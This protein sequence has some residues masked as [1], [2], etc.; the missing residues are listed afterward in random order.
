MTPPTILSWD[1]ADR[2]GPLGFEARPRGAHLTSPR[3]AA[4]SD[5]PSHTKDVT[6]VPDVEDG[7]DRFLATLFHELR[8]PVA[9]ARSWL[10]I[11]QKQA[12][13]GGEEARHGLEVIDRQLAFLAR[14]IEDLLDVSRI[15]EG[16][17]RLERTCLDLAELARG[18]V[19]D[20]GARFA[21]NGLEL[22]A[23]IPREPL[24]VH[25]DGARLTQV[26]GNLL[27]NA[28][29]F[30]PR[31]GCAVLAIEAEPAAGVACLRL[32]DTGSGF[33]P[34]LG[35]TLFRPFE[36]AETNFARSERGLGLGLALVKGIVELH[37]GTVE[38][39]SEGPGRGAEFV[40]RL[41]L[42]SITPKEATESSA[43]QAP[44]GQGSRERRPPSG[45]T[46]PRSRAPRRR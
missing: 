11:L 36:Q 25:G 20:H 33:D 35:E 31:G 34:S 13:P 32:R 24:W 38:A 28:A 10:F 19:E 8:S 30:T 5:E 27:Q 6:G 23:E 1:Q 40:V 21:V 22:R 17:L 15:G 16:K 9:T 42:A 4:G 39:W 44:G 7:K 2:T 26:M 41:P 3:V 14:L 46:E 43:R 12:A 29:K 37:G 45:G 18:A